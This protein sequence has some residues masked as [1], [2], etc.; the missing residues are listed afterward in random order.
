MFSFI[1]II[2]FKALTDLIKCFKIIISKED[3]TLL[4]TVNS[5]FH[6]INLYKKNVNVVYNFKR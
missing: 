2:L 4:I 6:F 1:R 5:V 3:S